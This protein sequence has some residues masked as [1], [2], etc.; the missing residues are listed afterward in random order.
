MIYGLARV[1]RTEN[2][3][4]QFVTST[5]QDQDKIEGNTTTIGKV[6]RELDKGNWS[7]EDCEMECVARNSMLQDC[8]VVEEGVRLVRSF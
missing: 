4:L 6:V 1:L 2:P 5:L 7:T 3:N 8:R